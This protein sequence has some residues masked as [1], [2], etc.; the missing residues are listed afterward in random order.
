MKFISLL[1]TDRTLHEFFLLHRFLR[2]M[3]YIFFG[4]HVLKGIQT[5]ENSPKIKFDCIKNVNI[6]TRA[7]VLSMIF[8]VCVAY[9]SDDIEYYLDHANRRESK[10][11]AYTLLNT[12]NG[13]HS[14]KRGAF[15]SAKNHKRQRRKRQSVTAKREK[16]Q[17]PKFAVKT[18][19]VC[20]FSRL[21]VT[22]WR[23]R[24]WRLWFLALM[25]AT[26]LNQKPHPSE[27]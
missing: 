19:G 3:V 23:L 20:N 18:F 1:S 24:R 22:D 21:A 9:S 15:D 16:S 7:N 2:K 26:R 6:I 5:F 14:F 17:T 10:F 13:I 27:A 8:G 4:N 11:W 12:L 25:T